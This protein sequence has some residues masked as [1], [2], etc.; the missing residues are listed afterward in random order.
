MTRVM[1]SWERF[2][3]APQP[4]SSLA[5]FRIAI[6]AVAFAWTLSLLPDLYAFFSSHGL[7]PRAP[8]HPPVGVWGVLNT[9]PNYSVAI[10]LFVTL[11][12]ASLCLLVGYHTRLASVLV[13]VGVLSFEHRAPSIW[14]SG[15][16][17][18]RIATFFLM[19]AP[20]GAS[21]SVDR[22][23][24][25]RDRFWEF[26]ARAPWALRLVQ[27][28]VS[29]VYLSAVWFKLHGP[30]WLHGTA[31]SYAAR[32][33]DY[34]RFPLPAV[35]SHSPFFSAA[36][37]Y[38]TMAVELMLGILLWNRRARPFVLALGLAL[39]LV[40][41]LSMTLAFF[42]ETMLACYLA[43]V[44]P[45]AAATVIHTVRGV[46]SAMTARGRGRPRLAV[47]PVHHDRSTGEAA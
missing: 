41:G 45:E 18:L 11:L 43:F 46:A 2:W 21:L 13:F 34:N 44:S 30:D 33:A 24:R 38:W 14:N 35:L 32:M 22:W 17:L 42:S 4:T 7:E 29:A 12:V 39:H 25:A 23:R 1:K 37:T 19:L 3:F 10:A 5:M 8:Y 40:L 15:D 20:A 6:G 27:I 16:G 31:V 26:P 47:V 9:F 28:Q 36:M